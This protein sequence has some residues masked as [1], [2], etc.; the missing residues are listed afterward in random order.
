MF[1]NIFWTQYEYKTDG[2][3]LSVSIY[4]EHVIM[5][6]ILEYINRISQLMSF[7]YVAT[8]ISIKNI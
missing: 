2:F 1:T 5:A 3:L 4:P 7:F 8:R 6:R